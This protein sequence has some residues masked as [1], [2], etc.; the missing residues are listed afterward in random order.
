MVV[1]FFEGRC[2]FEE[3]RLAYEQD[4]I[5]FWGIIGAVY[6]FYF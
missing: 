5:L 6:Y 2:N 3:C 4:G 1:D